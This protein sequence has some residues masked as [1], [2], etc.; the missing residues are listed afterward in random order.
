MKILI[1]TPDLHARILAG[2]SSSMPNTA[3]TI[4]LRQEL[5]ELE[6]RARAIRVVLGL[7]GEDVRPAA[8]ARQTTREIGAEAG[9]A[10]LGTNKMTTLEMARVVIRNAGRPLELE[11]IKQGIKSTFGVEPAKTLFDMLWKGARAGNGFVREES[12]EIGLTE[13]QPRMEAVAGT[14]GTQTGER[15]ASSAA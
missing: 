15:S 12:G 1:E 3:V 9:K 8:K 10:P 7:Y 2:R 13:M 14:V 11:K 5:S 4:A 6:L